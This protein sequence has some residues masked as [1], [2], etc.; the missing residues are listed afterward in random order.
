M[1][2]QLP[3]VSTKKGGKG[4]ETGFYCDFGFSFLDTFSHLGLEL[5]G[6]SSD[7]WAQW[8]KKVQRERSQRNALPKPIRLLRSLHCYNIRAFLWPWGLK[9]CIFW[10]EHLKE[11]SKQG[12][13]L[14]QL[15]ALVEKD[16]RVLH[17][18]VN[19]QSWARAGRGQSYY[20]VFPL[21]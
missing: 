13:L 20:C 15:H 6:G 11:K 3:R 18:D 14:Y 2:L 19:I 7:I 12:D 8:E 4:P 5:Q 1:T 17:S 21:H 10:S 16:L 9:S